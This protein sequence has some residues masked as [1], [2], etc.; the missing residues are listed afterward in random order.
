MRV[1]SRVRV[2]GKFPEAPNKTVFHIWQFS[3]KIFEF[4]SLSS[5]SSCHE[6]ENLKSAQDSRVVLC[7]L[8]YMFHILV[9]NIEQRRENAARSI[10]IPFNSSTQHSANNNN[11][12]NSALVLLLLF[13]FPQQNRTRLLVKCARIQLWQQDWR[14]VFGRRRGSTLFVTARE[15][16]II[17]FAIP[18]EKSTTLCRIFSVLSNI[19]QVEHR[20]IKSPQ[21][22]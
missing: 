16:Y 14:S 9:G 10:S 3:V 1:S 11:K 19:C 20:K 21:K 8:K 2:L 17:F 22:Y 13:F 6:L 4:S 18:K 5:A 15:I 7:T 12:L